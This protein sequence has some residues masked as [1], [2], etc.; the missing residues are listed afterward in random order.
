M[1]LLRKHKP[2]PPGPPVRVYTAQGRKA[3]LLDPAT[4]T[5]LCPFTSGDHEWKGTGSGAERE[6]AAV[7]PL[8]RF[9][10]EALEA[11]AS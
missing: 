6:Y 7:I 3:H 5:T 2:V 1:K 9:C 10:Q 8:C 4:G 11:G